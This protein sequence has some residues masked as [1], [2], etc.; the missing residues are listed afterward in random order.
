MKDFVKSTNFKVSLLCLGMVIIGVG[1]G[2]LINNEK[3]I[4]TLEDGSEVIA[5]VDG[6]QF[7]ADDLFSQLKDQGGES[8]LTNMIDE[9][10][11]S[12]ELEDTKEADD[13]AASYLAN[14]KSQYESYG[15]DFATALTN[16][17]YKNEDEFK[18]IVA[19]DRLKQ[20][21]AEKFIKENKD[22]KYFSQKEIKKYYDEN[23]TGE[24]TARYILIKPDTTDTMTDA[25]KT[26]AEEK[27]LETAN[28][29][30]EK[31]KDGDDFADLAK[32]YSDDTTT[33]SEGGLFSGFTKSDVVEE[34]WNAVDNLKDGKYTTSPVKSSYGYFIISRISQE[35]KPSLEDSKDKIMTALLSELETSDTNITSKAWVQIRKNYNLNIV[36]SN[37]KKA[38]DTTVKSLNKKSK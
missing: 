14:L 34:F 7:T 23:I 32:E 33:A 2:M 25:E 37:I 9:Y 19:K 22:N 1:I 35:D 16:A 24:M 26:E 36:D 8:V 6:K 29:V 18:K 15:E 5:E 10:I 11:A 20:L 28:E 4:P 3:T 31:L 12:V 13:Y 21:V 27:A 17:G 38:Y 30:I